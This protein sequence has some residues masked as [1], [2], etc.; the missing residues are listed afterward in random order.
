METVMVL[1]EM[2]VKDRLEKIKYMGVCKGES[3]LMERIISRFPK[4]VTRYV[5]RNRLKVRGCSFGSS[6]SSRRR[7]S[8]TN[9]L[10]SGFHVNDDSDGKDGEKTQKYME[11]RDNYIC[12]GLE[13]PSSIS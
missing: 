6:V 10:V 2:S 3:E 1:R 9:C 11:I 5:S 7:N 12:K 4:M 13:N 8:E